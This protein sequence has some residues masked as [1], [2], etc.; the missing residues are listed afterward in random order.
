MVC[1]PTLVIFIGRAYA[2][3]ARRKDI[4]VIGATLLAAELAVKIVSSN[5]V[6]N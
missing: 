2:M 6:C 3:Y 1:E 5:T 4:A